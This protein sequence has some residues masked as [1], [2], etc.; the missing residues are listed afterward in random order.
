MGDKDYIAAN[1][2]LVSVLV[3]LT[4]ERRMD[5][6]T[7]SNITNK[8]NVLFVAKTKQMRSLVL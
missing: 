8:P 2:L 3:E 4:E 1:F 7:I 6:L 5:N